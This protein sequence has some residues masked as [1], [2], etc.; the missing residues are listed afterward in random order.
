MAEETSQRDDPP[1]ETVLEE[2]EQVVAKLEQGN[3]PL[4][5]ALA[6]FERG[7]KL[8]DS[9]DERLSAAE[10]RVEALIGGQRDDPG[11]ETRPFREAF[12]DVDLA[13]SGD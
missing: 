13:P 2:L 12:P 10:E 5:D 1:F 6:A 9:A 4:G 3:L 7:M 8:A 11:A